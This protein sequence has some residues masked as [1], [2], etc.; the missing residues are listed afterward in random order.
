MS[1]T[2]YGPNT[3]KPKDLIYA[4]RTTDTPNDDFGQHEFEYL[5]KHAAG[6]KSVSKASTK[7]RTRRQT[8]AAA[9]PILNSQD[10]P[11]QR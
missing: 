4:P 5:K 8:E 11:C 3:G 7:E 10:S 2:T 9:K 6:I 1:D